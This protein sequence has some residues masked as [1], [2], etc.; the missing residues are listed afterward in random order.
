MGHAKVEIDLKVLEGNY[1]AIRGKIPPD[2]KML[3]VVKADGYGHGAVPVA[4]RLESAGA[5][6]LGVATVDEGV[7]LRNSGISLPTLVMGGVMPW[8]D[9]RTFREYRLTPVVAEL[10]SLQRVA[11]DAGQSNLPTTVHIK[12]DTGMGRLG[13]SLDGLDELFDMLNVAKHIRVEGLMSH[14]A[15][16]EQRDEYGMAQ[17]RRFE[18]AIDLFMKHA[19]QPPLLHMANSGAVCQY[20]ESYFSMVRV[21]IMLYG[22]YSDAGLAEKLQVR[23]VMKLTSRVAYV[24]SFPPES[25]LSYGRTFITRRQTKVAYIAAGYADGIPRALSNKGAVLL[26]GK[27]CP[28]IGRVCMDWLLVDV[29][30]LPHVTPGEEAVLMGAG[31]NDAITA[32]EIAAYA[33][34]IPYEILCSVSRR[35]SREYV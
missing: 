21:G 3:C 5:D 25:A 7:E 13:L 30:D 32:D 17:I 28:I 35:M 6:F 27:R 34:T 11:Q 4:R 15:C 31:E 33:G 1:R 26:G 24:K 16:S 22:S 9:T 23:P 14:F 18:E 20:P 19:V 29:T 10:E 8:D 2:V 12:I